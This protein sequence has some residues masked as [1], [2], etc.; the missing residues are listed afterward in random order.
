MHLPLLYFHIRKCLAV[1]TRYVHILVT[2]LFT[3]WVTD[4]NPQTGL[5]V[6]PVYPCMNGWYLIC[7]KHSANVIKSRI[8]RWWD[9]PGLFGLVQCK[10][11][12]FSEESQIDRR[13]HKYKGREI[14][15]CSIAGCEAGM[16]GKNVALEL[17]KHKET[18][19]PPITSRGSAVL[20]LS[21]FQPHDTISDFCPP[22]I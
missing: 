10:Y 3:G 8:L 9:Y 11:K 4:P 21:C 15:R 14:W 6:S 1:L 7:K 12:D 18:P 5:L 20:L 19:P 13:G 17:E 16:Q 22:E 2:D